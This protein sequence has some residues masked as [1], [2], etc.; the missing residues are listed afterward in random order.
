LL[1]IVGALP[2]ILFYFIFLGKQIYAATF[3]SSAQLFAKYWRKF[4]E[5]YL[6][7]Y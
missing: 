5:N 3:A 1:E 2:N 6:A 4:G 7:R